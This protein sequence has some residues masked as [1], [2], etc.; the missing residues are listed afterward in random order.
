MRPYYTHLR[1]L[2]NVFP[3]PEIRFSSQ[4]RGQGG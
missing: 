1:Y 3:S 4:E 2:V